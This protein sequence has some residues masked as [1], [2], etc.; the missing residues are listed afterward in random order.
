MNSLLHKMFLIILLFELSICQEDIPAEIQRGLNAMEDPSIPYSEFINAQKYFR[1]KYD[2]VIQ[3]EHLFPYTRPDSFYSSG[4]YESKRLSYY[5]HFTTFGYCSPESIEAN[6]CCSSV[7]NNVKDTTNPN[8]WSLIAYGRSSDIDTHV[9]YT[10]EKNT[11]AIFRSDLF[12]KV[13]VTFPGTI[14]MFI[15]F[16]AEIINSQL[17]EPELKKFGGDIKISKYF[18]VRARDLL[19]FIFT[20]ENIEKMKLK[21]GYQIIFTGHS[22]GAAMGAVTCLLALDRGYIS[23]AVNMPVL[24][25]YGQPRT[26]NEAFAITLNNYAEVIYRN[27]NENDFVTDIPLYSSGY[28]HTTGEIYSIGDN[29]HYEIQKNTDEYCVDCVKDAQK[30]GNVIDILKNA[31]KFGDRHTHYY[32]K[33]IKGIC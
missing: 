28:R 24:I 33:D 25:T 16:I 19:D 11:Y 29:E 9:V 27:V 14:D 26:G 31:S 13:V 30:F 6:E 21:E 17:V 5:I 7:F 20:P 22:L 15:Q 4:I 18:Y 3:F 12:K 23:R 2:K 32:A 8:G 1:E 10:H